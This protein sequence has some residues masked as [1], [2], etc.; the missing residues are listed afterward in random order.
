MTKKD[1]ESLLC[2]GWRKDEGYVFVS[3]SSRDWDKVYPCV[4]ELRARGINVF[5]DVEFQENSSSNWLHN[6]PRG[7]ADPG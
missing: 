5:I 3:Y 2:D 7:S 6:L 4:L 1:Y